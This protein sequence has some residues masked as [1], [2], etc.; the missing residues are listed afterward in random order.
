M[1]NFEG[2][3]AQSKLKKTISDIDRED[4]ALGEHKTLL[5]GSTRLGWGNFMGA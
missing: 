4:F 2:V 1:G 3:F 5:Q